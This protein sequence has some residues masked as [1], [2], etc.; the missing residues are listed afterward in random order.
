MNVKNCHSTLNIGNDFFPQNIGCQRIK[1]QGNLS[2][3]SSKVLVL[4]VILQGRTS[5]SFTALIPSVYF[6]SFPKD[7]K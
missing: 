4:E 2:T 3:A 6:L 5:G 7:G 1:Q